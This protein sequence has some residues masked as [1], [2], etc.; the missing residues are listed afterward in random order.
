MSEA[1]NIAAV[2]ALIGDPARAC[3]LNTLLCGSALT[4][5][6]LAEAAG[7]TRQTASVHL[8][9][10]EGGGLLA[11]EKQGRHAYF[12]LANTDVAAMVETLAVFS[13]RP[14]KTLRR[15]GPRDPA[16]RHARVCYD[17][18]A[19]TLAVHLLDAMVETGILVRQDGAI[20]L[21][22]GG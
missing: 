8:A 22:E 2:G 15:P 1:P 5:G 13:T 16:M 20:L 12:R 21:C 6:E 18:L 17:H 3:I 11:R 4:A 9:R 19:G 7:I 10:L 14:R